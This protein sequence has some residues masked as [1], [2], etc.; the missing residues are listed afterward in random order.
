[1]KNKIDQAG[2]RNVVIILVIV[3]IFLIPIRTD[4][5]DFKDFKWMFVDATGKRADLPDLEGG[6]GITTIPERLSVGAS[7]GTNL[8]AVLPENYSIYIEFPKS[9]I[10]LTHKTIYDSDGVLIKSGG[11]SFKLLNDEKV[12]T[13]SNLIIEQINSSKGDWI[14]FKGHRKQSLYN[15]FMDKYKTKI[16]TI[17]AQP[18]SVTSP[19]RVVVDEPLTITIPLLVL[20]LI[21][22]LISLEIFKPKA[23]EDLKNKIR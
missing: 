23:W 17:P 5:L 21:I 4:N 11:T 6:F 2:I 10:T 14:W 3:A 22:A 20:I 19:A 1:M 8:L 16:Y 9:E 18:F 12:I 7:L 15:T 13:T